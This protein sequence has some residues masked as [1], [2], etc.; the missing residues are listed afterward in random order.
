MTR[1]DFVH[2]HTMQHLKRKGYSESQ[3]K[4]AADSML[5]LFNRNQIDI[6]RFLSEAEKFAKEQYGRPTMEPHQ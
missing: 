1:I 5:A 6:G 3:A 2:N 4:R